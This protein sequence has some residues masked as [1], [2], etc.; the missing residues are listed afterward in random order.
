MR[1][2]LNSPP[3]GLR[4]IL[5]RHG[6]TE[7]NRTRR[8]QGRSDI[9][10][11][12][13]GM[14]QALA[15]A[16]ALRNEPI[17][18]AGSSPL[19]RALETARIILKFHPN[20]RLVMEDGLIEMDL[21]LFDGMEAPRLAEEYKGF[22]IA[23]INDPSSVRMPG[24]ETLEDVQIRAIQA[25]NRLSAACPAGK[26]LLLSGHN[27]VNLTILCKAR[28]MSLSRLR[29][30]RQDTGALNILSKRGSRL[31]VQVLNET[32]HLHRRPGTSPISSK[33]EASNPPN[34]EA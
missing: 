34:R 23:W 1:W 13:K 16:E 14:E 4:I 18:L 2:P 9:P 20:T 24:G 8:F 5:I 7:W 17:G 22:L 29:E 15:L 33:G 25:L 21:G 3:N 31:Q 30:M 26:T 12:L 6:E 28:G 19:Q 27:F 32:S 11:S 10:L